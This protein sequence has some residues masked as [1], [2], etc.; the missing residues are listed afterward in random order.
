[1]E[2]AVHD[3]PNSDDGESH[4]DHDNNNV[5]DEANETDADDDGYDDAVDVADM[6]LRLTKDSLAAHNRGFHRGSRKMQG[7]ARLGV[8]TQL[9]E[10]RLRPSSSNSRRGDGTTR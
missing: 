2:T 8:L 9:S 6:K 3:S 5:F 7:P 10:S 1:M 4:T